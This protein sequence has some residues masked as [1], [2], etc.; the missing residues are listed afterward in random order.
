VLP[1]G[2]LLTPGAR[3][4]T[5]ALRVMGLS[6]ERRFTIE[7][8]SQP[9]LLMGYH[10][11]SDDHSDAKTLQLLGSI[12][13]QG[14]TSRLYRRLVE[15]EKLAAT[16]QAFN[17]YPGTKY[18]SMFI[19]FAVPNQNVGVDT[20]ETTILDEIEKVKNGEIDNQALERARTKARANRIRSP[21]SNSGMA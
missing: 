19:T 8:E 7:G 21:D 18:E 13:S 20:L 4:L 6:G 16:V 3:T 1:L 10:T 5:A 9:F 14:R 17:G 2:A 12:I 11:V 15:N